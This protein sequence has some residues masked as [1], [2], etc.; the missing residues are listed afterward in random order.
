M[1]LL[2]SKSIYSAMKRDIVKKRAKVAKEVA[3]LKGME[4][5]FKQMKIAKR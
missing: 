2:V 3:Q 1:S 4:A 5:T